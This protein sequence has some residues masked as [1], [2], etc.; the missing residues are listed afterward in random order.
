MFFI[1]YVIIG[2]LAGFLAGLLGIGG[3]TVLVPGLLAIFSHAN[4]PEYL[5]M[6]MATST[7]LTSIIF[8]SLIAVYHQ[9][10]SFSINWPYYY[11][12]KH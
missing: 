1:L 9:Q 7:A 10:R 12:H 8:T 5:Q 11:Q 4:I 2:L 6:H 3:G